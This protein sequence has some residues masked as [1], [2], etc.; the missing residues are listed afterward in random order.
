MPQPF[1]AGKY[2]Q[3]MLSLTHNALS[4][5]KLFNLW[6]DPFD[7]S[8]MWEK[9]EPFTRGRRLIVLQRPK[10]LSVYGSQSVCVCQLIEPVGG[11]LQ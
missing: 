5:I 2:F 10:K 7:P 8:R 4:S 9:R 1:L 6:C 3:G 11:V